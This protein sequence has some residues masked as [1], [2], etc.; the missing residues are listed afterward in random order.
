[1]GILYDIVMEISTEISNLK[2]LRRDILLAATKAKEGHI[3]S[4]YSILE[5]IYGFYS[6][7]ID[8]ENKDRHRFVLSKGHGCLALYAVLSE[9]GHVSKDWKDNFSSFESAF[10]GHPDMN[11]IKG[12]EASTGSLGHGIGIALGIAYAQRLKKQKSNTFVLV[13]DGELNEGTAWES[14][15]VAN[16]HKLN[17]FV[18][19]VDQNHSSDRAIDLGSLKNKF[20]AFGFSVQE[21]NGH[22][23]KEIE[24]IYTLNSEVMAT[25]TAFI[26]KTIKGY[27]ISEMEN[28]PAYHHAYPEKDQLTAFLEQLK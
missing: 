3:P 21:I 14:L 24:K 23:L 12:V 25:P 10:G 1:M 26:A 5:L 19:I 28:N 15:M 22:N 4:A 6:L 27:G 11:K 2:S 9:F 17:N 8:L 13:G 7:N 18:V 16:H 20:E